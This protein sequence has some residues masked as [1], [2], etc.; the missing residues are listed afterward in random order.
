MYS[1]T[2]FKN[3]YDNKTNKR[4]D[5][6]TWDKFESLLYKLS[7]EPFAR[8]Q[9]A[10]LISPAVFHPDTTRSN[11]AVDKWAGWAA[12]DVDDH[13]FEGDLESELRTRFGQYYFVCYSTASSKPGYPKFR[14]VFP[15]MAAVDSEKIKHFWFA[16][17]SELGD[18]GDKQTK[19]LSRMYFIPGDYSGADSFIFTNHGDYLNPDQLMKKWEYATK[20]EGKTFLDRLPGD[21]ADK[22]I[23]S[24]KSQLDNTNIT[25]TSYRDCPFWP[26]RMASEYMIASEGWYRKMY[27]IM[28]SIAGNAVYRKYPITAK[29]VEDLCRE[30]D[31]DTGN[32]YENRPMHIEA[33]KAIEF[34]YKN[35]V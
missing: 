33:D 5:F 24:R 22:I 32:W 28:V 19:D 6:D 10:Y 26:R 35:G 14:L 3:I 18:I 13:V 15:L 4:L 30:F 8:K 31:R 16:L 27:A 17:N 2:I 34:I 1:L 7:A 29:E 12:V 23:E 9:D 21:W 25:W 11:K 20:S